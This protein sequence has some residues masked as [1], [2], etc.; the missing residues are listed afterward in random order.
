[1]TAVRNKGDVGPHGGDERWCRRARS[2]RN[3]RE[4][5]TSITI[6]TLLFSLTLPPDT[7]KALGPLDIAILPHADHVQFPDLR[8]RSI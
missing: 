7:P 4:P 6:V 5:P 2:S 1:V 3:T 8:M